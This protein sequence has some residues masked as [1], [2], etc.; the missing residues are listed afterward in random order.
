MKTFKKIM[1]WIGI[2]LGGLILLVL[3]VR[4]ILDIVFSIQLR[5][6]LRDLKAQGVPLTAAEIAPPPVPDADNAA[7]PLQEAMELMPTRRSTNS[8]ALKSL[9]DFIETNQIPGKVGTDIAGWT[10]AQREEGTELIQSEEVKNWYALLAQAAN[11]P[12]Y[13]NNLD[14][15]QKYNPQLSNYR[16]YRM[17]IRV[18]TIKIGLESQSGNIVAALGTILTGLKIN[19]KLIEEPLLLTHLVRVACDQI[20]IEELER[21]ADTTD[22]PAN[23][24]RSLITELSL[25]TA[26][27]PW[28]KIIY[29]EM[30]YGMRAYD[31]LKHAS[32][33]ELVDLYSLSFDIPSAPALLLRLVMPVIRPI[34]K[35]DQVIYLTLLPKVERYFEQPYYQVAESLQQ[36]PLTKQI[37][38]YA[39]M[40]QLCLPTFEKLSE[41]FAIHELAVEVC[42]VGLALKLFKQKA[43]AYPKTLEQLAP[44]FLES[45]P[46]DPFT[47]KSL[48]YRKDGDGFLLYSLGPNLKDDGG[49]ARNI[50]DFQSTDYDIVWKCGK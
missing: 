28:N 6:T 5:D 25:L 18:L 46:V 40:T 26:I 12:R 2:V 17:M 14:Y 37:P 16:K 11:R 30:F 7:L 44:E 34:Y 4:I 49:K 24:I 19:N 13:N 1:K 38:R 45:I 21:I 3:V 39:L 36:E 23:N 15:S 33:K 22:I 47:G 43:G 27:P 20:L 31:E 48:V 42:R 41:R 9:T 29:V 32:G 10:E 50:V 35:K 8:G